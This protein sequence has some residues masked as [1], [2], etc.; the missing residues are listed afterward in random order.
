MHQ[1]TLFCPFCLGK[2]RFGLSASQITCELSWVKYCLLNR[3]CVCAVLVFLDYGV[4]DLCHICVYQN[5]YAPSFYLHC[6]ACGLGHDSY[7]V[8]PAAW[9]VSHDFFHD[10]RVLHVS[11]LL[12]VLLIWT[13]S[14][15]A[16]VQAIYHMG[17]YFHRF[18]YFLV[19]APCVLY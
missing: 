13:V 3:I 8:S 14:L 2:T 1:P 16:S 6:G 18:F 11:Y 17:I 9:F 7:G 5:P 15:V 12:R 4:C 10:D 19:S